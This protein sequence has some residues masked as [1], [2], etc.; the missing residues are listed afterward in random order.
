MPG[1]LTLR[2]VLAPVRTSVTLAALTSATATVL[3]AVL[4][5]LAANAFAAA[6]PPSEARTGA[7]IAVVVARALLVAAGPM[8]RSRARSGVREHLQARIYRHLLD[9]G[10]SVTDRRHTGDLTSLA[11]DA[12]ERVAALVASFVP[13]VARGALAPIAIG[14]VALGVDVPSGLVMIG[15]LL[16][17]PPALR[18]LDRSFRG[19]GTRLR[20]AQDTLAAQFLD[21]I[22]GL[23]TL[24]LFGADSRW[25]ERLAAGAEEVRSDTMQVL[26]VAQ[27]S[28]ITVDFIYSLVSV[29]GLTAFLQ[30]RVTTG[31]ITGPDAVML[32]LLS[33]VAI[34]SLVD[35]VSFFYVGG[36]GLAA[37]G[38]I[39]ELFELPS[40]PPGT[41]CPEAPLN[42]G[43]RLTDV[44]YT[45]PDSVTPAVEDV[46]LFFAP[47]ESVALVGPSGAGKSTLAALIRGMR[48]PDRGTVTVDGMDIADTDPEWL[49]KRVTYVGQDT[50]IFGVSVA[51]NLR[52][53]RPEASPRD[54]QEACRRAHLLEVIDALPGGLEA[55]VGER[56][57]SLS[58][59]EAQRLALARAFLADTPVLVVDE[60]TSGLDLESEA[61]VQDAIENLMADRTTIVIA[62][63]I[64]TA[65]RCDRVVHMDGGRV[66]AAGAPSEMEGFFRRMQDGPR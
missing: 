58:G 24:V 61:L 25:S 15:G 3:T 7:M 31:A 16:L 1:S 20:L 47:G 30:W 46:T 29:V 35:V 27:R 43:V 8:L 21:S 17:V 45:Y 55:I 56:G 5:L 62:H 41:R 4:V 64:T 57:R 32:V 63:R 10:P 18:Y 54:M 11:I 9:A 40:S 49:A 44:T 14:A 6:T 28:L 42:G 52:M 65:R 50:H 48:H 53:A 39:R 26:S 37:L 36:L 12:V 60:A 2:G 51:D 19:A 66:A 22:Q 33:V 59:G 34:S 13:L 23:E 38:R